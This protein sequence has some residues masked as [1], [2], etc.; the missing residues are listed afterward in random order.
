MN[1]D[2]KFDRIIKQK[3]S[4]TE[5][6]FDE[7]AW[8]QAAS[9]IDAERAAKGGFKAGRM[10]LAIGGVFIGITL[11]TIL[12]VSLLS[13]S[14]EKQVASTKDAATNTMPQIVV[15][16]ADQNNN[17][18]E[19]INGATAPVDI[20]HAAES[21]S[22]IQSQPSTVGD[23]STERPQD[24]LLSSNNKAGNSN[25]QEVESKSIVKQASETI[26]ESLASKAVTEVIVSENSFA[27]SAEKKSRT[28]PK[29]G[30]M[31]Q[32]DDAS[33]ESQNDGEV[34]AELSAEKMEMHR[35]RIEAWFNEPSITVSTLEFIRVS[36]DEYYKKTR[37]KNHYM[38]AEAG[39]I[40]NFGWLAANG[41]DGN[42]LNAFAGLNYGVYLSRKTSL[43]LGLQV[44]NY[45][46]I[47]EPFY[48]AVTHHYDFGYSGTHKEITSSD[49]YYAAIPIRLYYNVSKFGKLGLGVNAAF[50]AGARSSMTSYTIRDGEKMDV[51]NTNIKGY[52]EGTETKNLQLSVHYNHRFNKR[53]C[54]NAEYNYGITDIFNESV[55]SNKT[56]EIISGARVGIQFMIFDK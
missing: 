56:K 38:N 18:K 47:Q 48:K 21:A 30:A 36:D 28:L 12:T 15:E 5:F 40:Y 37:R 19:N 43:S 45:S 8:K 17:A 52:Y 49:L 55:T 9:M 41:R 31:N 51:V 42:G 29:L 54:L 50:L 14:D 13:N 26:S 23:N 1:L 39:A 6:E 33:A 24:N 46:H 34:G 32:Q 53:W 27:A 35:A 44:Y 3:V 4:N 10:F 22:P 2:D 7:T 16:T 20:N 11:I 25:E